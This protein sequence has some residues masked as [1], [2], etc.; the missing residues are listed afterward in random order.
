MGCESL[1]SVTIPASVKSFGKK[2]FGYCFDRVTYDWIKVLKFTIKGISDT[3]A[4]NYAKNNG[5]VF[6]N[7]TSLNENGLC[8]Y[9]VDGKKTNANTKV[10]FGGK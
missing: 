6:E 4:E 9:T 2:A 7:K 8:Y 3:A 1:A 10:K 5:F